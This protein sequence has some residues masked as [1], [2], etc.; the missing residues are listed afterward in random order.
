MNDLQ[1]ILRWKNH[2]ITPK[3]ERKKQMEKL[4]TQKGITLIALI[5]TI[6]VMLILVAVTVTVALN[7]GLFKTAK[8]ATTETEIEK[9]KELLLELVMGAMGKNGKVDFGKLAANDMF[10]QNGNLQ[11]DVDGNLI[12]TIA[13]GG[14]TY[15]ITP[16]GSITLLSDEGG[17]EAINPPEGGD[18]PDNPDVGEDGTA[19]LYSADGTLIYSWSDLLSNGT[20]T[21]TDGTLTCN[22]RNIEGKLIISD[23]VT[24]IGNE[25]FYNCA[26]LSSVILPSGVTNIGDYA[27][28]FCTD[29]TKLTIP[30]GVTSIGEWA[31]C[32]SVNF[33]EVNIP[34]TVT[35]IG[36]SAFASTDLTSVT[37]PSS[38]TSIGEGVFI[39]QN[40]MQINVE[41]N[42]PNYSSDNGVLYNKNKTILIQY[43]NGKTETNFT[44]PDSVTTIGNKAFHRVALTS[45]I[46]PSNVTS[47]GDSAF[48]NASLSSLTI[49][50]G[51]TSIGE[52]AF[53]GCKALTSVTIPSS[54][55]SI[56]GY[57]FYGCTS[58]TATI[59]GTNVTIKSEAFKNVPTVYYAGYVEGKNYSSW[60]AGQVLPLSGGG[61]V[62]IPPI[63]GENDNPNVGEDGTAGLYSTD[64]TFTS[65]NNLIN[66]GILIVADGTLS[67][68]QTNIAGKLIISDD[69]T[70]IGDQAFYGCTGLTQVTIPDSVTSIG[71]LSFNSCTGLT[72]VTIPDSVTS[73]GSD[74]FGYCTSLTVTILGNNVT[75]GDY[76]FYESPIVYYAGYVEGE[77]YSSWCSGQVLPIQ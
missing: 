67:C 56:G 3:K 41:E 74:S 16:R 37:I 22:D 15:K 53:N 42:N 76:A 65:W 7:G 36:D 64:G 70:N 4:K 13:K 72:Q 32:N 75:I 28:Y 23:D 50:N 38:V 55:T 71:D 17:G 6:I 10:V 63:G 39:C 73:I 26:K 48:S 34:N 19:G 30:E 68:N 49:E 62:V 24:N 1:F 66:G 5:I 61:E 18:E 40:T 54:V 8:Q 69:V 33:T 29:L 47:I 20:I 35:T 57:A 31:F 9:E 27:F 44:I 58:L 11:T 21:V 14:R 12:L 59:L 46:I 51:V 45:L 60:G 52:W 43:P 77:D 25:A 2:K